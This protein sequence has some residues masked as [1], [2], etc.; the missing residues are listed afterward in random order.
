[1]SIIHLFN[2][3]RENLPE[4]AIKLIEAL[5]DSELELAIKKLGLEQEFFDNL[6]EI[7]GKTFTAFAAATASRP[8]STRWLAKLFIATNFMIYPGAKKLLRLSFHN[9]VHFA[10]EPQVRKTP[11]AQLVWDFR[12]AHR[13]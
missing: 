10:L 5:T 3:K 2:Q 7:T 4:N 8:T 11:A 6:E 12:Q 13:I 9:L 1:L